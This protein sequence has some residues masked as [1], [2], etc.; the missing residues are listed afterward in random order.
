[1]VATGLPA[2]SGPAALPSAG[3]GPRRDHRRSRRAAPWRHWP[4]YL[5]ISPFFVL[6]L[7]FMV[8]PILFSLYL[9]FQRW[10]G[11]GEIEFE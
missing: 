5:A 3:G 2:A 9:S 8:I 1:M 10:N 11:L 6:F 7:T 4:Q